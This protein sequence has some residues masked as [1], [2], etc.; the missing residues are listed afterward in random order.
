MNCTMGDYEVMLGVDMALPL[1]I[2]VAQAQFAALGFNEEKRL[3]VV[4]N[5]F[6]DLTLAWDG[7]LGLRAA[8]PGSAQN[9]QT[10]FSVTSNGT[11]FCGHDMYVAAGRVWHRRR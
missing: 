9:Y 1:N 4:W 10:S 3:S 6:F 11:G 2:N 8:A 5:A 7:I